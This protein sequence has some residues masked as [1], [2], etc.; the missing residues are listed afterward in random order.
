[1]TAPEHSSLPLRDYDHLPLPALGHRIRPLTADEIGQLLAYER[2][3][4]N[5]PAAMQVFQAR[6]DE[7]AAGETPSQGRRQDGPEWPEPAS[8]GPGP[9]PATTGPPAFPS[10]HGTPDQPARQKADRQ[11]P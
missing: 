2:E 10:P 9:G 5:R 6:L 8:G 11:S 4:A 3:H 1:M 7:L